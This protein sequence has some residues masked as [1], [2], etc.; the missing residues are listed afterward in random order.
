MESLLKSKFPKYKIYDA[1]N[2]AEYQLDKILDLCRKIPQLIVFIQRN[3]N[4]KL[5]LKEYEDKSINGTPIT[6]IFFNQDKFFSFFANNDVVFNSKVDNLNWMVK[7]I[8]RM[9]DENCG[10]ECCVCYEKFH[11]DKGGSLNTCE[12]CGSS[13]CIQCV[14]QY[15]DIAR[16]ELRC[17]VSRE[18][19]LG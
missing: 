19:V 5:F 13:C 2:K 1:T 17:P 12:Q 3:E 10:D 15:L 4:N 18:C 14:S 11:F 6:W 8:N 9:V 16:K 7:S